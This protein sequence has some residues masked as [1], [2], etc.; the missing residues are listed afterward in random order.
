M[1]NAISDLALKFSGPIDW[2]QVRCITFPCGPNDRIVDPAPAPT[3]AP[4][5]APAPT[6]KPTGSA[7]PLLLG[8]AYLLLA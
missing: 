2:N 8:A 3:P 1:G 4:A 5:P 6:A 7:L